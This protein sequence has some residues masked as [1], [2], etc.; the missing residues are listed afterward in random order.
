MRQKVQ[1]ERKP[2]EHKRKEE[3]GNNE[4]TLNE[5]M[6]NRKEKSRWRRSIF[7]LHSNLFDHDFQSGGEKRSFT[8]EFCTDKFMDHF[9]LALTKKSVFTCTCAWLLK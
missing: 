9:A 8:N 3:D 7:V 6:Q 1:E 2:N 5:K 4:I